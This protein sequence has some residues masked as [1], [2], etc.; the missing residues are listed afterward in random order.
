[1]C[2]GSNHD[3][4]V[5]GTPVSTG[6]SGR[7]PSMRL[8]RLGGL[9][10]GFASFDV[11]VADGDQRARAALGGDAEQRLAASGPS[12]LSVAMHEPRPH[13]LAASASRS[14]TRPSSKADCSLA[15]TISNAT[16]AGPAGLAPHSANFA[17]TSGRARRPLRAAGD[18]RPWPTSGR[19]PGSRRRASSG[20]WLGGVFPDRAQAAQ[21]LQQVV[22]HGHQDTDTQLRYGGHQAS[23][24]LGIDALD[25]L[26]PNWRHRRGSL[27]GG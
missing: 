15:V 22:F 9:G 18:C 16:A 8:A 4:P 27:A 14:A 25:G 2:S 19:L 17:S 11:G 13:A 3:C 23:A 10:Q 1:M 21:E 24:S 20:D 6:P 12:F 7:T 26:E 5:P